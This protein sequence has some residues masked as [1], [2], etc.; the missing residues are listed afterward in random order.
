[1]REPLAGVFD[2][3]GIGAFWFSGFVDAKI[4][5]SRWPHTRGR[6]GCVAHVEYLKV[7]VSSKPLLEYRTCLLPSF[8]RLEK[9]NACCL[10]IEV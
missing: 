8:V 7:G 2:P 6:S 3:V 9:C 5:P 4:T 1:M 10:M